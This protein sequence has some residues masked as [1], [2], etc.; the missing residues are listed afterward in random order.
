MVMLLFLHR[1]VDPTGSRDWNSH[2]YNHTTNPGTESIMT[3]IGTPSTNEAARIATWLVF[4]YEY[5]AKYQNNYTGYTAN[6]GVNTVNGPKQL[7]VDCYHFYLQRTPSESEINNWY[8][9]YR[10][11]NGAYNYY[12][13]ASGGGGGTFTTYTGM[14]VVINGIAGSAEAASKM[15]KRYNYSASTGKFLYTASNVETRQA[16]GSGSASAT[17]IAP[18][19][20]LTVNKGTGISSVTGD[21]NYTA[22]T[23]VTVTATTDT[24]YDWSKWTW[25]TDGN[26]SSQEYSFTMPAYDLTITANATIQTYTLDVNGLLDDTWFGNI[27]SYGT[28]D[29]YINGIL[30]KSDVNDYCNQN[31]PYGTAYEVKNVKANEGYTYYP[32]ES[33]TLN[34]TIGTS[35]VGIALVFRKNNYK[36]SYDLD[37]GIIPENKENPL[38]YTVTDTFTIINPTRQGYDFVGWT[39]SNDKTANTSV[40]IQ[41]GTTGDLTYKANWKAKTVKVTFHRNT[42]ET[43]KTIAEQTFTYN[44]DNQYFSDKKWSYTGYTFIGWSHERTATK[45][46]YSV[47]NNVLNS[48]IS[49]YSPACDLYAVW[50]ANTYMVIYDGNGATGGSMKSSSHIYDVSKDLTEN[51]FVR[52][53]YEFNGWNTKADGSGISYSDKASVKSLT[54]VSNGTVTLYAQWKNLNPVNVKL[55]AENGNDTYVVTNSSSNKNV[56]KWVNSP[57]ILYA[58]AEDPGDGIAKA[59]IS[60]ADSFSNSVIDTKTYNAVPKLM[61]ENATFNAYNK[62]GTTSLVLKVTDTEGEKANRPLS[63]TVSTKKMTLK[64]DTTAPKA[65]MS[66]TLGTYENPLNTV[67][68][69]SWQDWKIYDSMVYG[70]RVKITLSDENENATGGRQD[71]SGIRHAWLTVYDTDNPENKIEIEL[72][73]DNEQGVFTY[74]YDETLN[75]NT[76]FPNVMNLTYEIHATDVAGNEMPV[77]V[78]ATERKPEVYTKVEK[79]TMDNLGDAGL[80]KAGYRGRLYIYTTGWVD[81]LSLEWSESITKSSIYDIAHGEPGML[82][83]SCLIMNGLNPGTSLSNDD[84]I[85]ILQQAILN[86]ENT[87]GYNP[88]NKAESKDADCENTGFTRCYVFDFWIPIYIGYSDNAN[89]LDMNSVNQVRTKITASKYLVHNNGNIADIQTAETTANAIL[90]I[91]NG[92]I[93]DEF[94]TSIIN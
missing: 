19:F 4:S 27:G 81:T 37:G 90:R 33:D 73:A 49:D 5:M 42:S 43:D 70:A 72:I 32:D 10:G 40:T 71:V 47:A 2:L 46:T 21:G 82:Y 87:D 20:K 85:K 30:A 22:G 57:Y 15:A 3:G 48:W 23:T 59:V 61:R 53:G 84:N 77:V 25:G 58:N 13:S 67:S 56:S 41:K 68:T 86:A 38:S 29:M 18:T 91:G 9:A 6:P 17:I 26:S 69:Q 66:V 93:M 83:D 12:Y 64:I 63:G 51:A 8:N 31:I 11:S 7:I 75:I 39:G 62:E 65:T 88:S 14:G 54:S 24:G 1:D 80:F 52:P 45:E 55:Y 89:N 79:I 76:M 60:R 16:T 50:E 94:H 36:I 92:S 44:V 78:K 74:S 34:G 35:D 28:F